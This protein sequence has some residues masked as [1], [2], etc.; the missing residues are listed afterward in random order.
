VDHDGSPDD[1]RISEDEMHYLRAVAAR[2]FPASAKMSPVASFSSLRPLLVSHASATKATREHHIYRDS[3]GIVR[4][5]GGKYTTYRVMAEEAADLVAAEIAPALQSVHLTAITPLNGNSVEVVQRMFKSSK[6]LADQYGVAESE[7]NMLIR[8][9]GVMT[10]AVLNYVVTAV[11]SG[12][13]N[14][15]A[16]RFQFAARHEMAIEPRDFLEVSTSLGHEGFNDES[17]IPPASI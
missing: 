11:F 2:I 13:A 6:A 7:I 16:A 9:Y 4:I 12:R 3:E 1:V 10:P 17:L 8:Q 14:I 15:D 5:T